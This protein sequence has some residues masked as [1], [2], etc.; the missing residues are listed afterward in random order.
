MVEVLVVSYQSKGVKSDREKRIEDFERRA[1][2]GP[3]TVYHHVTRGW[4]YIPVHDFADETSMQVRWVDCWCLLGTDGALLECWPS[5]QASQ[6]P[7]LYFR[8]D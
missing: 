8:F 7:G 6:K 5:E 1:S 2:Y 3:E 4:R